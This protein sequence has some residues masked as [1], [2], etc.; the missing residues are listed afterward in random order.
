MGVYDKIANS[1][2]KLKRKFFDYS[3]N[4]SG[5]ENKVILLKLTTNKY[6]DIEVEIAKHF[7]SSIVIDIPGEIP[8]DRLR[9][10]ITIPQATTQSVF[11]YDILPV[12]IYSKFEDNIERGD[13]IVEKIT[14]DSGVYYLVLEVAET[15]GNILGRQIVYK[16]QNAAPYTK[17]LPTEVKS[18]IENYKLS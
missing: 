12:Q 16:K 13:I 1:Q 9:T 3:V 8:I 17:T 2:G 6:N 7:I 10:D 14:M 4:N 5:T 18:I 15:L 11:L